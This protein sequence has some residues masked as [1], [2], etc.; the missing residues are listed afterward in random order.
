MVDETLASFARRR[1]AQHRKCLSEF[2]W[3]SNAPDSIE[4]K[5][6]Q[7]GGGDLDA[8]VQIDAL[9]RQCGRP[10][11]RQGPGADLRGAAS[12]GPGVDKRCVGRIRR[13]PASQPILERLMV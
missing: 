12:T 4:A 2:S 10:P 9:H 8:T 6:G 11:G 7:L 5:V 3:C 1:D 13:Q